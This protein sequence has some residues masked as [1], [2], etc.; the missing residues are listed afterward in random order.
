MTAPRRNEQR[1]I[2]QA[3]D[4]LHDVVTDQECDVIEDAYLNTRMGFTQEEPR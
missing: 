3:E 4:A 1:L 2:E